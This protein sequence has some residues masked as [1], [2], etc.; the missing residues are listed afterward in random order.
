MADADW[1][2]DGFKERF[3]EFDKIDDDV[4]KRAA[5]IFDELYKTAFDGLHVQ[6]EDYFVAHWLTVNEGDGGGTVVSK[7][8]GSVSITYATSDSGMPRYGSFGATKYGR[9]FVDLGSTY[10]SGVY[11][12]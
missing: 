6:C 7:S 3:P 9:R 5:A 8:V 1:D 2:V 4:I 10:D 11:I 12:A